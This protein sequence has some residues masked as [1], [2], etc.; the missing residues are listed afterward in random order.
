MDV[1][2]PAREADEAMAGVGPCDPSVGVYVH[3]PFC[4][5]VCPY[6]DFAVVAARPLH[7]E[8]EARY[9]AA[10]GAELEAR[11]PVF[12][13]RRLASLYLGGGTPSLLEAGSV[14]G[15]VQAV[16]RAF[17]DDAAD[18]RETD[19]A[20]E[21]VEITLEANP[22]TTERERLPAFRE[23][24]VNRLSLGIQSFDDG[25]LKRLGRAHRAEEGLRSFAAARAAGFGNVSVDLIF[26]GPGARDATLEADLDQIERL[27]PEH[28]SVYELTV[29][30]GTPFA[31]AAARGQLERPDEEAVARAMERI[32]ERLGAAG[33]ERY[34]IS[35]YARPGF[36]SRHNRRYWQRRPVLGLGVGAWSTDPARAEAPHGERRGNTRGLADYLGRI[37]AGEPAA[38]QH[39]RLDARTARGE[40]MFLGLRQAAGVDAAAFAAEFGAP[41]RRFFAAEIDS[42]VELGLLV[43]D[44]RGHLR[45]SARGRPL[46]D[47]V[48]EHFV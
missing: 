34:E 12:A 18:A 44:P 48:F 38:A 25:Q 42:L 46:S 17:P 7:A 40:A 45:L 5:R 27:A 41:P 19:D 32:E 1:S 16:R 21:P 39:E 2:K 30:A 24:G 23:A 43:E 47:G 35:S 20:G 37:E 8:T 10:L 29:E 13:G 11:R 6:C 22:G 9:V 31:L 26:A 33:Y 3:V 36:A 15:L 14:A 4:E 28:V